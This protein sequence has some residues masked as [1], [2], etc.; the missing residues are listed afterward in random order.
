MADYRINVDVIC[1]TQVVIE[2]ETPKEAMDKLEAVVNGT[3]TAKRAFLVE[4]VG[5]HILDDVGAI[6]VAGSPELEEEL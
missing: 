5:I 1:N 6:Q 2:A 3:F 4:Q